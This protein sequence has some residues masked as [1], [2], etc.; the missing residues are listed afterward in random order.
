MIEKIKKYLKET[1][2]EEVIK[3]R[4][5]LNH[6]DN[7]GPTC[8]EIMKVGKCSHLRVEENLSGGRFDRCLDCGKTWGL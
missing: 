7:V 4:E 1:P 5:S 8:D 2:K 6:W 3:Q